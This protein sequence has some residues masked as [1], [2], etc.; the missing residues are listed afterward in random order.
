MKKFIK[1]I[2]S[3][4]IVTLLCTCLFACGNTKYYQYTGATMD[5]FEGTSTTLKQKINVGETFVLTSPSVTIRK[6]KDGTVTKFVGWQLKGSDEVYSVGQKF[7]MGKKNM[8][9]VAQWKNAYSLTFTNATTTETGTPPTMQDTYYAVGEQVVLPQCSLTNEGF[10]FNGWKDSNGNVYQAGETYTMPNN[11]VTFVPKWTDVYTLNF[12]YGDANQQQVTGNAPAIAPREMGATLLIPQCTFSYAGHD[13]VCWESNNQQ[14]NVGDTYTVT[15]N[16]VFNAI[17][18][19][20]AV[21]S[22]ETFDFTLL[23]DQTYAI[24][25]S[26][27]LTKPLTGNLVLPSTFENKPVTKLA[28]DGFKNTS[29]ESV[30][31][32]STIT[33]IGENAFSNCTNLFYVLIEDNSQLTSIEN[34]AFLSCSKLAT[35]GI[36]DTNKNSLVLPNAITKVGDKAFYACAFVDATLNQN[37][38]TLGNGVFSNQQKLQKFVS[39]ST[40]FVGGTTLVDKDN[41]AI[42]AYAYASQ[43]AKTPQVDVKTI[44]PYTFA[45][46]TLTSITIGQNVTT[47]DKYAF[48]HCSKLN[49]ITYDPQNALTTIKDGAF[50]SCSSLTEVTINKS[51]TNLSLTAFEGCVKL[52]KFIV[53]EQNPSYTAYGDN[54]Y[55]KNKTTLLLYAQNNQNPDCYMP[56]TVT[57]ISSNA[58]AYSKVEEVFIHITDDN[59][60]IIVEDK[61]FYHCAFLRTISFWDNVTDIGDRAFEYCTAITN[62]KI[63]DKLQSL[64]DYAFYYCEKLSTATISQNCSIIELSPYTFANCGLPELNTKGVIQV[65]GTNALASCVSLTKVYLDGV[66]EIGDGAFSSCTQLKEVEIPSSLLTL[67][68]NAF[69]D[70]HTNLAFSVDQDNAS[71]SA[72][73]NGNLY[74]KSK[75]SLIICSPKQATTTFVLPSTVD[76]ISSYAFYGCTLTV[77]DATNSPLQTIGSYAFANCSNLTTVKL[78]QTVKTIKSYAFFKCYLMISINFFDNLGNRVN[79]QL[80]RIEEYAFYN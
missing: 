8:T 36:K 11:A 78:P 12:T 26:S 74:N 47:I 29:I 57:K 63:G 10:G 2:V 14:Y 34:Y 7:T 77:F 43:D 79:Q 49:T 45:Y 60:E 58:F 16:A 76:T 61:A 30:T 53:D 37:L 6:A 64:G 65:I 39:N 18:Q 67:A 59:H 35:F 1:V 80:T 55:D 62:V 3:I 38:T 5:V 51:V 33:T 75:T 19:K 25:K 40:N 73:A 17:W 13:F 27:T 56:A 4:C 69:I 50:L 54:L 28:K 72:D 48:E 21:T 24:A 32:P 66:L 46:A 20:S 70:C 23:S 68:G 15:G 22:T 42:Y 71:F 9:F 44:L 31:I 41:L 52:S